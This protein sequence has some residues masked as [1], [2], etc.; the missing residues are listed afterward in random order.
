MKPI[1]VLE[2]QGSVG[3]GGSERHTLI[4]SKGLKRSDDFDVVI[5]GPYSRNPEMFQELRSLGIPCHEVDLEHKTKFV[6]S[7]KSIVKVIKDQEIDVIHTHLRNAD[8]YGIIAGI[9]TRIPVVTT[10]HGRTGP[11]DGTSTA[12]SKFIK[13][14]HAQLLRHGTKKII[15]ISD[16]VKEFNV[17]DLSLDPSKIEVIHNCTETD[18]F[19]ITFD[20]AAFRKELGVQS[21]EKLVSLIGGISRQK[22]A[23]H[24]VEIADIIAKRQ[25]NVKFLVA[26]F[27]DF[28]DEMKR[29]VQ[30]KGLSGRFIFAGWRSDVPKLLH[31]T[32]ILVVAAH[33]EGFGRIIAE[34][35][36]ASRPV[37]AF[38]SGG[39]P[40]IIV[41]GE[42]GYLV[43]YGDIEGMA[44]YV[45]ELLQDE[46]KCKALG[47]NGRQHLEEHFSPEVFIERT[48][49][50]LESVIG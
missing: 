10:L 16:F 17:K 12:K 27:G 18:R 4:L 47:R 34:A 46:A 39:V 29:R 30:R 44:S 38:A 2:I 25:G 1:K 15:A 21:H 43:T 49:N 6:R 35:M 26:G 48:K 5:I 7:L 9:L 3:P 50:V 42:T 20:V 23:H 40:E 33:Q 19:D 13:C 11:L 36:A 24:F 32:D 14:L 45:L 22:G 28:E 37:V 41:H 8:V 31:A